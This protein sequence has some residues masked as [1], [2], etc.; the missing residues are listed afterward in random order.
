M[1]TAEK[2]VLRG[3]PPRP[4]VRSQAERD[5][6]VLQY[7][8]LARHVVRQHEHTTWV[9]RLGFED[10][11]QEAIRGLIRAAELW[12]DDQDADFMTY[13]YRACSTSLWRAAHTGGL[14]HIPSHL[15]ER[16]ARPKRKAR[17]TADIRRAL[18]LRQFPLLHSAAPDSRVWQPLAP[19]DPD[20][21]LHLDQREEVERALRFLRPVQQDVIQRTYWQGQKLRE[22]AAALGITREAVRLRL[23]GA[24]AKLRN[25]LKRERCGL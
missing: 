12:R 4:A 14:I 1:P 22:I 5:V 11:I 23:V 21:D 3:C 15:L 8:P 2:R 24:M 13:A 16:V 25:V 20:R 10:A 17:R 18:R 9:R 6:L 7:L 19:E